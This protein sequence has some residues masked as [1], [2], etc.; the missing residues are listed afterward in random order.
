V[1]SCAG[2]EAVRTGNYAGRAGDCLTTD[3]LLADPNWFGLVRALMNE[4]I[5]S[6][7]AFGLK[8]DFALADELIDKTRVMSAYKPS[9]LIDFER[10]QPVELESIFLEPL[11]RAESKGVSVPQLRAVCSTLE[12]LNAEMPK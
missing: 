12:K 10:N 1:A 11:R 4:V 7:N 2:Y 3:K 6:G 8:I 9:T 5:A